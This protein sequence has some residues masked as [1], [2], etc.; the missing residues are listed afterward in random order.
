M[1]FNRSNF[2]YCNDILVLI[3]H[4]AASHFKYENLI[5]FNYKQMKLHTC[6]F[7]LE[8]MA[9][10]SCDRTVASLYVIE[11]IESMQLKIFRR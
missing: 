5:G 11:Y 4:W 3:Q 2:V 10:L 9:I 6:L 7:S 8:E 1:A